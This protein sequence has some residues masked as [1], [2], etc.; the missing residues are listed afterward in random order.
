MK[1]F[2]LRNNRFKNNF[3]SAN[4]AINK[5]VFDKVTF[6][7]NI[8]TYGF[9]DLVFAKELIKKD[10]PILQIDNPV[11]HLGIEKDNSKFIAKERESLATLNALY[12]KG[13]LEKKDVTLLKTYSK[14]KVFGLSFLY[15]FFYRKMKQGILKNLKSKNPSL[16]LF[17]IY[18][19]GYFNSLKH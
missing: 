16:F 8:M 17:D 18:R 11:I 7:E 12:K 10:Y 2:T 1:S 6:D 13:I 9:E 3:S 5:N 14:I 15:N 19:L 4:F